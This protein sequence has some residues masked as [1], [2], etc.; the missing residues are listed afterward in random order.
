MELQKDLRKPSTVFLRAKAPSELRL[1]SCRVRWLPAEFTASISKRLRHRHLRAPRTRYSW[2]RESHRALL[3]RRSWRR[4]KVVL[5]AVEA[6]ARS[7]RRKVL[8]AAAVVG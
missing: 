7:W 8:A 5:A 1:C 4:S 2:C 3:R 6:I